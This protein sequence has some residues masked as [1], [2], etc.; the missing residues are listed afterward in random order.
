M[1]RGMYNYGLPCDSIDI[2][3]DRYLHIMNNI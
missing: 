2:L 3:P 1:E